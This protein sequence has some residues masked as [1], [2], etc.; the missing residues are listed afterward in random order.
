MQRLI[1][2]AAVKYPDGSMLVGPRHF[3]ATM[4]R[5]YRSLGLKFEE[6]DSVCGFLDQDSVFL[7]RQDALVVANAA[8]QIRY[9][10]SGDET[11]LFSEN[12]Y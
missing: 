3:D 5:Q 2:C 6:S 12:L 10:T 7:N 1:V 4:L 8:N 9:R 11:I